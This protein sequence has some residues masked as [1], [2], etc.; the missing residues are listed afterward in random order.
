MDETKTE[1]WF[2]DLEDPMVSLD[3]LAP[4]IP[5]EM[6]DSDLLERLASRKV[7]ILR[8]NWCIKTIV[9]SEMVSCLAVSAISEILSST[10][11]PFVFG[12]HCLSLSK[13]ESL[14]GL[15][16]PTRSVSI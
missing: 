15:L 13:T 3:S 11:A 14:D 6:G 5:A 16:G 1:Q 4:T 2:R 12:S 10:H 9:S 7:P 8:A